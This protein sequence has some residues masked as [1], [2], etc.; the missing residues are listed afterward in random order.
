MARERTTSMLL[1]GLLMLAST[2][3]C[4]SS[5][6]GS[7]VSSVKKLSHARTLPSV[8][9][10]DVEAESAKEAR[11]LL[12]KPLDADAAVRIA[13]LNNRELRARLHELG[14]ARAKVIEASMVANPTVEV[15]LLPER[16][17]D[18]ELRVEYEITSLLMAPLKKRAEEHD[19]EAMRFEVA[20]AVVQLGY[21]V[22]T[23][24]YG[25]QASEQQLK[26]A[27]QSLDALAAGRDTAL[28]LLAA[29][30][31]PELSAATQ[32][33]GYERARI[34]VAQAELT[35]AEHREVLQRW[36]GLHGLETQWTLATLLPNVPEDVPALDKL[37]AQALEEN[38]DL[39]AMRKRLDA[40]ARRT[41]VARTEAYLPNI[42][43][44]VHSLHTDPESSGAQSQWRWGSGLSVEVPL[45]DRNQGELR[46][47]EA[48]FDAMLER[49][50]GLAIDLRSSARE[51]RNRLVSAHARARQYQT[52]IVPAQD[53]VMQQTLLQ[54]NAM[55]LSIFQLLQARREQLDV[56]LAYV[57][58]L[59][60]YWSARA[61]LQALLE[62]SRVQGDAT[63]ARAG[64]M[65]KGAEGGGH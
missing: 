38:L 50:Q 18:V 14:V 56:Q 46:G 44:D 30:N 31:I 26:L 35:V 60:E 6:I 29:G 28:A 13:L 25:L 34:A 17:S 19:L 42:A 4:V 61:E 24:F 48:Q 12:E 45:F 15:D 62:G 54:Y 59:R 7:D 27:Q 21:H 49:Y 9:E 33:A 32:I 5:S 47:Y 65:G 36:L 20:G 55:Q 58:T 64:L 16:D 22:R 10:D 52:V 11:A 51:T 41:G 1:G 43:V 63:A 23:A 53:T 37:E 39:R 8:R 2:T 57:D 3:S 40:L